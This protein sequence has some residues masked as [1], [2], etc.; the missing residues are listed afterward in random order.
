[1]DDL[2]RDEDIDRAALVDEVGAPATEDPAL[3]AGRP[4][5]AEAEAAVRTLIR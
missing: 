3:S 1:M 4:S 5:Q 2:P